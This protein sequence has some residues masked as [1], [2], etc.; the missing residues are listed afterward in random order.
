MSGGGIWAI[1]T[2]GVI[3][4]RFL[5]LLK[6]PNRLDVCLNSNP[7]PSACR[8]LLPHLHANRVLHIWEYMVLQSEAVGPL[9]SFTLSTLEATC[10]GTDFWFSCLQPVWTLFKLS[11]KAVRGLTW[12]TQSLFLRKNTEFWEKQEKGIME[13]CSNSVLAPSFSVWCRNDANH[14]HTWS[15]PLLSFLFF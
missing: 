10:L 11:S 9:P 6:K 1:V 8:V 4:S 13:I 3:F 7:I 2:G 5:T 15:Q 12:G 14:L